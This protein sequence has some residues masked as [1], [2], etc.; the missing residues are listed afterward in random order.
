MRKLAMAMLCNGPKSLC[1]ARGAGVLLGSVLK[2]WR[3]AAGLPK[4]QL[5]CVRL[6]VAIACCAHLDL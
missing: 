4:L 1:R 3:Y 5:H 2:L 6:A